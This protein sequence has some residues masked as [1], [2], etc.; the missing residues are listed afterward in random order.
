MTTPNT[1]AL[2]AVET[3]TA[4]IDAKLGQIVT[5]MSALPDTTVAGGPAAPTGLQA[6]VSALGVVTLAWNAIPDPDVVWD[7]H[8]LLGDPTNTYRATVTAP[9]IS[10]ALAVGSFKFVVLARNSSGRSPLSLSIGVTVTSSSGGT[11]GGTGT[12]PGGTTGG[13]VVTAAIPWSRV[14]RDGTAYNPPT[15]GDGKPVTTV[16]TASSLPS[17]GNDTNINYTGPALTSRVTITGKSGFTLKGVKVDAAAGGGLT[18]TGCSNY[19]VEVDVTTEPASDATAGDVVQ[20]R[21]TGTRAGV[22][23]SAFGPATYV[24]H[25][26]SVTQTVQ[27]LAVLDAMDYVYLDK[28][29]FQNKSTPGNAHRIYGDTAS[30]TGG[31]QYSVQSQVLWTGC[32]PYKEN[33]QEMAR[34]G[35]STMMQTDGYHIVEFC[36]AENIQTE[37]EVWS[38]KMNKSTCRGSTVVNAAGNPCFRHGNDGQFHDNY[39]V[40]DVTLTNATG[41]AVSSGGFRGYGRGH[42]VH[43]N[44]F[45]VNG[46]GNFQRPLLLDGGDVDPSTLSSSHAYVQNW[47]VEK[48]L[49]V[50]CGNAITIGKNYPTPPSGCTVQNN[51]VAECANADANGLTIVSGASAAGVTTTGNQVFA[52]VAAAGLTQ[53]ASGE[54]KAPSSADRGARTPFV[55]AA[56]AGKGATW[57]PWAITTGSGG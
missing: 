50:K 26:A 43:H 35:V 56:M 25:S 23:N 1:P 27:F 13:T 5:L 15:G 40:G 52:T 10:L 21:G 55:T 31:C 37:P 45:R 30:A 32:K 19:W 54:W 33:D 22:R 6:T 14:F 29:T 51:W 53:G 47:I 49:L 44:T 11:A 2:N 9:T 28:V 24:D 34:F 46:T 3:E 7:V 12:T 38:F 4:Q 57:N 8:E 18:I 42:Y 48:N 17:I 41:S 20:L 16:T 39:V 36:R